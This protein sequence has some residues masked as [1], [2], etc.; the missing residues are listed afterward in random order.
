MPAPGADIYASIIGDV[1]GGVQWVAS[2]QNAVPLAHPCGV[3]IL[4]TMLDAGW[5]VEYATCGTLL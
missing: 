4:V 2:H 5:V 1:V 3:V